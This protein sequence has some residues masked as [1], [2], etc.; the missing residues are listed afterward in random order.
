MGTFSSEAVLAEFNRW[1]EKIGANDPYAGDKTLGIHEVLRAHF[2]IADH[3]A[4]LG[5]GLGGVGPR[6]DHLLHSALGR[7]HVSFSGVPKWES[8]LQIIATLFFGLIKDHPFHDANK[9]TAFLCLLYHLEKCGRCPTVTEQELEDF[10]VQVADNR[11]SDYARYRELSG[12]G[13]GDPEVRFIHDFLKRNTREI[14]RR[15]YEITFH[16]LNR[17]LRRFGFELGHPSG[18]YIDV[19]RFEERPRILGIFGSKQRIGVKVAQIGFPGWTKKVSKNA[20][21]SVREATGLTYER[22][23][24]SQVFFKETDPIHCLI[25]TYQEPLQRLANR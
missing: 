18:N 22:G 16:E 25:A 11:L 7:Q 13:R 4:L 20:M 3:F 10:A 1:K 15:T 14:D 23:V 8:E 6:D 2:L 12:S 19:I 17:I 21:K 5:H 9:R 24:D